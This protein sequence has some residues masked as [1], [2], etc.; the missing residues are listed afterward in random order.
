M[1]MVMEDPM[2]PG[3]PLKPLMLKPLEPERK[4]SAPSRRRPIETPQRFAV[5]EG[6]GKHVGFWLVIFGIM[7]FL[8]AVAI[9]GFSPR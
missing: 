5:S 4:P 8:A 3:M 2:A 6:A 1:F 7:A 9:I